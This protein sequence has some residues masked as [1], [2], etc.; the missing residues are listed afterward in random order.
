[1][2]LGFHIS[3]AG[4]LFSALRKAEDL[5]CETIQIFSRNPRGWQ[6]ST[7]DPGE[8]RDFRAAL[9]EK[10][11]FPLIL[12]TSYLVNLATG[13]DRI[14]RRSLEA[15]KEDMERAHILGA[16]FVVTHIGSTKG[17]DRDRGIARVVEAIEEIGRSTDRGVKLLLEN[18][19]G[20]GFH[21]GGDVE[22][23]G[24]ILYPFKEKGWVGFCLDTCHAFAA[25]YPI[26][27]EEGLAHLMG[28]IN[29]RIGMDSLHL[30]HLNDSRGGL[31]SRIDRHEHI[32]KGGIGLKG[33]R[34]ILS[35]PLL[36]GLPMILETPK[37]KDE[38]DTKNLRVI[39]GLLKGVKG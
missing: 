7:I 9:Y 19:S 14:Y 12:H 5:G 32:G 28:I 39:R 35:H 11:I 16:P 20:S 13:E 24:R 3:V 2:P 26:H 25:G 23:I 38:D 33:F 36:K 27:R 6:A 17:R 34:H 1:M 4:G 31:G 22:E 30:I 37:E 29:S 15:I 18:S 8:A 10:G 21:I